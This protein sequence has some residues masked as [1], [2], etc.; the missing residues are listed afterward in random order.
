M[1]A[2]RYAPPIVRGIEPAGRGSAGVDPARPPQGQRQTVDGSSL[3][4][5]RG[6]KPVKVAVTPG[7][8]DG[9]MIAVASD[10]LAEGDPVITNQRET[11]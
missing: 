6:G 1:A 11:R 9:R 10:D 5:L 4:V 8:S 2:L 7:A 3:W